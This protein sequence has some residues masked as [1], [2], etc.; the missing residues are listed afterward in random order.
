MP[1]LKAI[2]YTNLSYDFTAGFRALYEKTVKNYRANKGAKRETYFDYNDKAFL[3]AN[4]LTEQALH[5]Y[6]EDEI[7]YGEPGPCIA[8]SIELLRRYYYLTVQSGNLSPI[9]LNIDE[10]PAKTDTIEGIAWLPRLIPKARAKLRGELP[11]T[12]MYCCAGDRKF[13]RE[14]NIHPVEFLIQVWHSS[15]N[16]ESIVNWLCTRKRKAM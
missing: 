8:H 7:E 1:A 11:P 4:G 14:H 5:D 13:F 10:L 2:N 3:A 6:A 16:T 15:Q 12:L 9:T